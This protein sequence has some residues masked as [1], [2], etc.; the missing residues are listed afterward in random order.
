MNSRATSPASRRSASSSNSIEH[1]VEGLVHVSTMADDYY[2][3]VES[4]HMLRGENTQKTYRLGD[5]VKVQVIRVNMDVRQID[6][7]LVEILERVREGEARAAAIEGPA[8][9]RTPGQ[10]GTARAAGTTD[11]KGEAALALVI[12]CVVLHAVLEILDGAADAFAQPRQPVCAK[13]DDDDRQNDE[14]FWQA[15]S[16]HGET[17]SASDCTTP[18]SSFRF[19]IP[20]L[21]VHP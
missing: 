17:P 2:R 4:A 20:Y 19:D 6:L 11:E 8:E 18:R 14:Q 5:K 21:L 16:T 10:E 12:R 9:T 15:D 1:Y 7:G 3:F 13:D